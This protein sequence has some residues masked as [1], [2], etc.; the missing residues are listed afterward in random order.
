MTDE[1]KHHI[2]QFQRNHDIQILHK[3]AALQE[4]LYETLRTDEGAS[5]ED[6]K[7]LLWNIHG[8]K[9]CIQILKHSELGQKLKP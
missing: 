7:N 8:I 6:L 9:E 2:Q 3:K 1:I 5:K 4:E